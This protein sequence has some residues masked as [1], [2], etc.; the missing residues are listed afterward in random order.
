MAGGVE[1]VAIDSGVVFHETEE[2]RK[3]VTSLPE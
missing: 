1:A 2:A 3:R